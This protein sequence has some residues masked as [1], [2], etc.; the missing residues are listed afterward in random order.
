MQKTFEEKLEEAKKH[1]R[2]TIGNQI[3]ISK[4]HLV[5]LNEDQQLSHILKYSLVDLPVTVGRRHTQP[6]PVI[7]L[8]GI[9]IK[10]N[11]ANFIKDE[12]NIILKPGDK[13]SNLYIYVNGKKIDNGGVILNNTDRIIFGTNSIFLFM[14]KSDGND[15]YSIDWEY[16]QMEIQNEIEKENKRKEEEKEKKKRRKKKRRI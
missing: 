15:I 2:E 3:D 12:N 13:N 9:G 14:V 1:E 6:P 4:P 16:A 11:H 8:S 5:V 10:S 7:Q